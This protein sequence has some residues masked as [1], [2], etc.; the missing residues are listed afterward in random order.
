MKTF[1][2]VTITM[3]AL[4][5]MTCAVV[6]D[7]LPGQVLK[8]SQKPMID[9]S[10]PQPDG[11]TKIYYGHDE[12]STAVWDKTPGSAPVYN[13]R[14]M[15][16][17]FADKFDREVVHVRWWGSYMNGLSSAIGVTKFLIAFERDVPADA[18]NNRYD[19][20]HPDCV[21]E[22]SD[23]PHTQISTLDMDGGLTPREG[24]F[25]VKPMPGSNPNEPVY[26][27]NAELF[28]PFPQA[29]DT[30]Y[31][32]KIV[33]LVDHDPQ[34]IPNEEPL[35][36]GWHNRDYT[37]FDPLA[38]PN[39]V[40]GERDVS[41]PTNNFPIWHFQDDAVSGAIN[42]ISMQDAF[43]VHMDQ[44][45]S[46]NSLVAE[47]YK[48]FLDGP[49]GIGQYSKDLA[50]QLYTVPEPSTLTLLGLGAL[51]LLLQRRK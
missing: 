3:A 18:P 40:P 50:F 25:T 1:V 34:Q 7:P 41:D 31:W 13:G 23:P 45:D 21:Y 5:L 28:S 33:A 44:D 29:A 51:A 46:G 42:N 10:I 20:S 15:A 9:T 49:Y 4:L 6:A 22:G 30:V 14:F 11:T 38:S 47:H 12:L 37:I 35:Q 8:F 48:D 27:Y 19:F 43:Y 36:W 17:D 2:R 32:L 24:T 16:D 39:V 26:E